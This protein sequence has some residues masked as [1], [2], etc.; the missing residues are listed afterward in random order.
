MSFLALLQVAARVLV[1]FDACCIHVQC[2]RG[3]LLCHVR[4][5]VFGDPTGEENDAGS[6][7]PSIPTILGSFAGS[8]CGQGV[9]PDGPNVLQE[10]KDEKA[11]CGEDVERIA[12]EVLKVFR[13]VT[14][15]ETFPPH[16]DAA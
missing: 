15:T 12:A 10:C 8:F 2:A 7:V 6:F 3:S 1:A 13:N 9:K 5:F 11:G 4:I 14:R 16:I